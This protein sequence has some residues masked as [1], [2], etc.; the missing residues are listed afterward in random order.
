[1]ETSMKRCAV[2]QLLHRKFFSELFGKTSQ[3]KCAGNFIQALFVF[4]WARSIVF[5]AL[6][7]CAEDPRFEKYFERSLNV[8]PATN[9][10]PMET[11]GTYRQRGKELAILPDK[12]NGPKQVSSVTGTPQHTDRIWDLPPSLIHFL[13]FYI[14]TRF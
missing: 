12:A 2:T 10:D 5:R 11:L 9:G 13:Q 1:M 6:T 8:Y 7:C 4:L 14:S 3:K